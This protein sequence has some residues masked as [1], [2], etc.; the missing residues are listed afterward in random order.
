[1]AL[2]KAAERT[3]LG[4]DVRGTSLET[5]RHLAS[6]G[7]G[8][9]LA[10]LLA[11]ADW[12]HS[13]AGIAGLKIVGDGASRLVRLVFKRGSAR[14]AALKALAVSLRSIAGAA[15]AKCLRETE[16]DLKRA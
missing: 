12:R 14:E 11:Y 15:L 3:A 1:L 9:T 4:A 8:A 5:L 2:C 6:A 13:G 7:Q 16:S 10:P